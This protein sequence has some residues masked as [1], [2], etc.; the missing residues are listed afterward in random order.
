MKNGIGKVIRVC[1]ICKKTHVIDIN[2]EGFFIHGTN[3]FKDEVI[4]FINDGFCFKCQ[5]SDLKHI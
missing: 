1:P 2:Q 3:F 5:N 4:N